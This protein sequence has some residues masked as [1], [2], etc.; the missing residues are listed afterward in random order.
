MNPPAED[1][2]PVDRYA[3]A[4]AGDALADAWGEPVAAAH[5][6]SVS[7]WDAAWAAALHFRGDPMAELGAANR[8]AAA[9]MAVREGLLR[10]DPDPARLCGV[11][12]LLAPHG[13]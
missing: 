2:A 8:T 4:R 6:S 1:G 13:R 9:V 7:A 3:D 11:P 5:P 10:P 12:S